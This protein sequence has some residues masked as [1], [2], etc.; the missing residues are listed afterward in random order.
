MTLGLLGAGVELAVRSM[1]LP[2]VLGM[3][4]A[5]QWGRS[6]PDGVPSP[7]FSLQLAAKMAADECFLISEI[8]SASF[9]SARE[10]RRVARELSS[11]IELY[12][13][14]GWIEDPTR[15]HSAPSAPR[16]VKIQSL[17]SWGIQHEHMSFE[18]RW[19]PHPQEP[20][21]DRWLGYEP[22]RTAHVRMLRHPGAPRPWI[23]C[24]PGYRMGHVAVDFLGFNASWLH[25]DLGLNVAIPVFPFHGPRQVGRRSG[26]G[27][28]RGDVLDTVHAQAQA[29]WDVRRLIGWLHRQ[30]APGI[31]VYGLS[32]GG[33]TAG[34]VAGLEPDLDCVIA[35]IPASDWVGLMRSHTSET[36]VRATHHLGFPWEKVE[37][38]LRVVSPLALP[39]RVAPSRRFLFAGTADRLAPPEQAQSLWNHWGRPRLAWY[40]GSHVSFWIEPKVKALVREALVSTGLLERPRQRRRAPGRR[41]GIARSPAATAT[42]A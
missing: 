1:A 18:S 26:D 23:V 19:E 25:Q 4:W 16:E 2:W 29:V 40:H 28:L 41:N 14:R 30:D 10:S 8:L 31:A 38:L 37:E 17:R 15:Y 42:R 9:I 21:R 35:G 27:F 12:K 34:L 6:V 22:N 24:T 33:Y 20:G 7:V 3:R 32:L 36:I 11:A 5:G 39:P 13:R